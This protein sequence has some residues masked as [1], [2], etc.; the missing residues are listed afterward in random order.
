MFQY[1]CQLFLR[2]GTEILPIAMFTDDARWKTPVPDRYE[3]RVANTTVMQ[4]AYHLIKLRNLDYRQYLDSHNP[5]AYG[6]MAKMDYN[7]KERVRLK[8]D[9]LRWILACP[10]DPAR[11]SLLVEFV[12]T[13]LPLEVRE[14][15]ESQ[16]LVRSA[17]RGRVRKGGADD[18]EFGLRLSSAVFFPYT[19]R[20]RVN[21]VYRKAATA[22]GWAGKVRC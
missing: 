6:L 2:Y 7:R 17:Q 9:F 19:G 14:Q 11:R 5:L 1:F 4:F 12:E 10:V 13:Y 8:A 16:Q 15:R 21:F 20:P 3:L 18:T 22:N